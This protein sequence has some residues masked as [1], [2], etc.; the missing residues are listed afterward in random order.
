MIGYWVPEW[1]ETDTQLICEWV[2]TEPPTEEE[3]PIEEIENA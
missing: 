3:T 2:E 1:R